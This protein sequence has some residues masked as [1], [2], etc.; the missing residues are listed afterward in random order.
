MRLLLKAEVTMHIVES[1]PE[2]RLGYIGGILDGEG[3]ICLVKRKDGRLTPEVKVTMTDMTCIYSLQSV[4]QVGTVHSAEDNRKEHYKRTHI[5]A[6]RSSLDIHLLLR[7][8][9]P[10]LLVK[11]KQAC[12]MLKFTK[13][14]MEGFPYNEIDN[15]LREE[16]CSLNK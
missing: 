16:M 8:V 3:S 5:W 1:L 15:E 10:Y 9:L 13:R 14:R 2:W 12:L 11:H 4:T 7:A 6:V